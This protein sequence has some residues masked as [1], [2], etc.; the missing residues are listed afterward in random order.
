MKVDDSSGVEIFFSFLSFRVVIR[1]GM[2]G[3]MLNFYHGN[4]L[5]RTLDSSALFSGTLLCTL[6]AYF[7]SWF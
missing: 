2:G 4:Q 6:K 7:V 1:H 3:E 5:C